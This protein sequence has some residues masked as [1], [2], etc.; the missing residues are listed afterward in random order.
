MIPLKLVA[1]A[2][3]KGGTGKS[4]VAAYTG[5]ALSEAKKKTIL[6]EFGATFRSLDII[7]AAQHDAVFDLSDVLSGRCE[8][9]KAVVPC[10]HTDNLFLIPAQ[11]GGYRRPAGDAV[12][13]LFRALRSEYDY[14]LVDGVD[15]EAVPPALFDTILM[16]TTP[17][18]LSVRACQHL[19][20]D[21]F[22]EGAEQVR[23]VI[24]N[25]PSQVIP[26]HGAVDFDGVIDLIGAQLIAVIPHSPKLQ[27]SSNNAK[28][29]DEE[30]ATI[31]VFDNLAARL[32]G[33]AR[34]L[35]IR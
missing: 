7:A 17:D 12:S 28:M 29:L 24:N 2:S 34:P 4:C 25:V 9:E 18:T 22:E 8:L 35:L 3:G 5:M 1:I 15:F 13:G 26:I 20:R 6:V 19:T 11:A 14:I 31:Q 30:S 32:C 10:S 27:Y 33:Q 16:V 21:L 23:L